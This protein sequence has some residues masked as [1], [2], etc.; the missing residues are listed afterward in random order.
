MFVL[1]EQNLQI[2]KSK[3]T[4]SQEDKNIQFGAESPIL[5]SIIVSTSRL[6]ISKN[7]KNLNHTI[8]Q[9]DPIDI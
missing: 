4:Q 3:L 7:I 1:Y 6:K 8:N 5:F 9:F 2:H